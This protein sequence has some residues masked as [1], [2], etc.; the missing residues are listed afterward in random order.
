[1]DGPF[2]RPRLS[3]IFFVFQV[4]RHLS[5]FF[6]G[7]TGALRFPLLPLS[8]GRYFPFPRWSIKPLFFLERIFRYTAVEPILCFSAS[9]RTA[10]RY[11]SLLRLFFLPL[12]LRYKTPRS[13]SLQN[14]G[15]LGV[16]LALPVPSLHPQGTASSHARRAIIPAAPTFSFVR[17]LFLSLMNYSHFGLPFFPFCAPRLFGRRWAS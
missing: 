7:L 9:G 4:E 16:R 1:M 10:V 5:F 3:S 14:R 12:S 17:P 2:L 15:V 11:P 13:S 6:S 8:P